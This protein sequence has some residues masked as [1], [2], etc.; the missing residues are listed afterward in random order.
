MHKRNILIAIISLVFIIGIGIIVSK[1]NVDS[2]IKR[3]IVKITSDDIAISTIF[4][5]ERGFGNDCFDIYDFHFDSG[6]C[7]SMFKDKDVNFEKSYYNTYDSMIEQVVDDENLKKKIINKES[8]I[9]S[10]RNLMYYCYE[11]KKGSRW[12]MFIYDSNTNE[13][14]MFHFEI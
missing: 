10:S 6:E 5:S 12:Y 8:Q 1:N 13:G 3:E 4:Q 14:L 11:I 2:T 7:P 9:L